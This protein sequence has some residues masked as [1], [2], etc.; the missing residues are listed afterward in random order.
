MK[1]RR[2]PSSPLR[3]K[4]QDPPR[5]P[6]CSRPSDPTSPADWTCTAP[7]PGGTEEGRVVDGLSWFMK[8]GAD[9]QTRVWNSEIHLVKQA[10]LEA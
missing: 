8:G 6:S 10:M 3:H 1:R 7:P 4:S 9:L 5:R 2:F